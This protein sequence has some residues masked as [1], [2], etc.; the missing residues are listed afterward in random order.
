MT[1]HFTSIYK[2]GSYAS[3][4]HVLANHRTAV[5]LSGQLRTAVE[6]APVIMNFFRFI[7]AEVDFYIHTWTTESLGLHDLNG[8]P[9]SIA[10][11]LKPVGDEKLQQVLD[12]YKPILYRV[13]DCEKYQEEYKVYIKQKYGTCWA[14]I[15]M[16]QSLWEC[17]NLKKKTEEK[18]NQKYW[19][20][21]RMRFDQIFRKEHSWEYE[22]AFMSTKDQ[23][24][25]VCD[26]YNRLPDGVEDI[27]WYGTSELMDQVC[28]F[29]EVRASVDVDGNNSD[30]QIHHMMYCIENKIPVKTWKDNTMM[31]YRD[32]HH[33][34]LKVSPMD[35]DNVLRLP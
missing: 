7:P 30:W 5:C 20:V 21:I 35:I 23:Y 25:Y 12:I 26:H 29:A 18:F 22:K 9:K 2:I 11:I 3:N 1:E 32:H 17:N 24:L 10:N 19:R 27:A 33:E 8:R 14:S 31:I 15:P 13:D 6:V 16:F 28:H 34:T 4:H